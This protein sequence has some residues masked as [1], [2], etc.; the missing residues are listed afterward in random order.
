Q[1][2]Y[3][4]LGQLRRVTDPEGRVTYYR[5][6]A[7]GLLIGK[8]TPDADGDGD[9]DPVNETGAGPDYDFEYVY[10]AGGNLRLTLDPRRVVEDG[11]TKRQ[12]TY[13]RYDALGRV[14]ESGVYVGDLPPSL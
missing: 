14:V 6:D 8:T 12:H 10:D 4:V 3:D 2:K 5:Y 1:F 9:G 11:V 13:A 7:R